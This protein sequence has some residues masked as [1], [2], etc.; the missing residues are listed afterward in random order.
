MGFLQ[1]PYGPVVT[2]RCGAATGAGVPPPAD[3]NILTDQMSMPS[4][5]A[6]LGMP[7]AYRRVRLPFDGN[8]PVMVL[9]M[10]P[11]RKGNRSRKIIPPPINDSTLNT[12]DRCCDVM[13]ATRFAIESSMVSINS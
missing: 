13:A 5:T 1:Y 6:M 12:K 4:P 3:Q 9:P 10:R 2:N 8:V 11:R 7:I